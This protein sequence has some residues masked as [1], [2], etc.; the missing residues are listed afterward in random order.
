M[1]TVVA[2]A[3]RQRDDMATPAGFAFVVLLGWALFPS[4]GPY[5]RCAP[6]RC[7]SRGRDKSRDVGGL[8]CRRGY[9]IVAHR[10]LFAHGDDVYLLVASGACIVRWN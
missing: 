2:E 4:A 3:R 6:G 9:R 10:Q 5:C 8:D 1:P 7:W